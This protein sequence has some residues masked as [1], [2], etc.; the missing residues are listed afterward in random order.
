MT[1]LE[2]TTG[3]RNCRLPPSNTVD[4]L[5]RA[6]QVSPL[7][8]QSQSR[9]GLKRQKDVCPLSY[10]PT[11][12]SGDRTEADASV[13]T[14]PDALKLW[15]TRQHRKWWK[16]WWWVFYAAVVLLSFRLFLEA[17][18]LIY[19]SFKWWRSTAQPPVWW[20]PVEQVMNL[21]T[22]ARVWHVL[23]YV[24]LGLAILLGTS[25]AKAVVPSPELVLSQKTENVFRSISRYSRHQLWLFV[26]VLYLGPGFILG[27]ILAKV[28]FD[29]P[30]TNDFW[31]ISLNNTISIAALSTLAAEGQACMLRRTAAAVGFTWILAVPFLLVVFSTNTSSLIDSVVRQISYET[32]PRFSFQ[33]GFW[34]CMLAVGV[35]FAF[36]WRKPPTGFVGTSR[37]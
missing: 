20:S 35:S 28:L 21:M 13:G 14:E 27:I 7:R 9:P 10:N 3:N 16:Q 31:I 19:A 33:L 25:A 6:T 24:V 22:S 37:Q 2:N 5:Q 18:L 29:S 1:Q 30:N 8:V 12:A 17:S 4:R 15:F 32:I 23:P 11:M 26:G 34:I 36:L